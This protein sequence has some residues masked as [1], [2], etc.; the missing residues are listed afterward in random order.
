MDTTPDVANFL[1]HV[2]WLKWD[3]H[4]ISKIHNLGFPADS[5]V[6]ELTC[7]CRR[8]EDP[9]E[10]KTATQSSVLSWEISRVETS[11]LQP[12][13]PQRVRHDWATK[14]QH[15]LVT[16]DSDSNLNNNISRL[17]GAKGDP[18]FIC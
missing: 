18:C 9:L 16:T 12:M 13:G 4:P 2:K 8:R 5:V 6:K 1:Q 11:G 10:K 7:Q 14:Q 3:F 15:K 17:G